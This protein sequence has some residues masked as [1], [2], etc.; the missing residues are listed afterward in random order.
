MEDLN[1]YMN[2]ASTISSLRDRVQKFINLKEEYLNLEKLQILS[3]LEMEDN[4]KVTDAYKAAIDRNDTLLDFIMEI[5][6]ESFKMKLIK[7]SLDRNTLAG[8]NQI[9]VVDNLLNILRDILDILNDD[10]SKLDR[11]VRYYEKSFS[12]YNS[13]Y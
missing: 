1:K 8:V 9:K 3:S 10:R 4:K 11:I 13:N 2:N 12:Y 7:E 5:K 6:N